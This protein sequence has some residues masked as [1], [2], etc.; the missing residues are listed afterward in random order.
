VWLAQP[1]A[2]TAISGAEVVRA[3][4]GTHP[5]RNEYVLADIGWGRVP[6]KEGGTFAETT[7]C[8]R[9]NDGQ[10][11]KIVLNKKKFPRGSNQ[12][13]VINTVA[14]ENTHTLGTGTGACGCG[15]PQPAGTR[16]TDGGYTDATKAW[17]VSYALGDLAQCWVTENGDAEKAL[18]CL[19]T[20]LDGVRA[21]RRVIECC[22]SRDD[23]AGVLDART[24]T[25][26]CQTIVCPP[27]D[28]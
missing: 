22:P 3:L 12:P 20:I 6:F 9:P 11:G 19:D 15:G 26:Y 10:C 5:A 25:P 8:W 1:D 18:S 23:N 14:H 17:L 21:N 24:L 28:R 16:F 7:S 13:T 27:A 2:K 4:A